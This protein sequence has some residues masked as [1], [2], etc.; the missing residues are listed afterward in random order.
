MLLKFER[1]LGA[2]GRVRFLAFMHE[3]Q[4]VQVLGCLGTVCVQLMWNAN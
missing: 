1:P 3:G 2:V 4:L